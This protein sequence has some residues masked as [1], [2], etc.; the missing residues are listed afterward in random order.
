M[1]GPYPRILVVDDE[2]AISELFTDYFASQDVSLQA[3]DSGE[4]A[5][6]AL[7]ESAYA[8]IFCDMRMP[9]LSGPDLVGRIRDTAPDSHIVVMTG[10]LDDDEVKQAV[11]EGAVGTLYKPFKLDMIQDFCNLYLRPAA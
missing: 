1:S 8:L 2:E 4:A 9:G 3:V 11:A 5:L 6:A 7:R 10:A